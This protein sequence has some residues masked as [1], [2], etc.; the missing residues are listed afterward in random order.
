MH[1]KWIIIIIIINNYLL[2]YVR[3][4]KYERIFIIMNKSI[5]DGFVNLQST[6]TAIIP[7]VVLITA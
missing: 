6:G 7:E 4:M 5:L 1:R 3:L 2:R